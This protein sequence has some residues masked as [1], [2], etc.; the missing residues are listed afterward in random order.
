VCL[1]LVVAPCFAIVVGAQA[2]GSISGTVKDSTGGV[3]PGVAVTAT[4]VA[5]GTQTTVTTDTQGLYSF[6]RLPVGRYDL[7]IQLEGFKPQK[8]TGL[9]V[10]ADSALQENAT[11][12]V[13]GQTETVTVT[14]TEV[15]VETQST[16]LGEVVSAQQMTTLSLN[17]RSYTDLLAIQ[18]GVIPVTTIQANSVIMAGVTGT[19]APS[20]ELNAGNVSVSG[21]RESANGFLVNGGDVQEHMNGGTSIVPNLDSIE[22]FRLLTNNFDPQYGNYNGGIVNVIT[23][24]GSD[25]FHGS[26]FELFRNTALDGR[27]YFSPDRASFNQN[28]PG[29]TIGGPIKKGKVFFFSDYQAT[30]TTQGVETGLIQVPS[31]QQRLGNF[32]DAASSLSGTVNGQYWA[33]LLAQH[34]GYRVFP[35]EAYYTPGCTS[36]SQCVF[37]NAIIP[38]SAW[39][40]PAQQLLQYIPSQNSGEGL[41][42]TGAYPRTVRDDKFSTRIDGNTR[43]GLVSGY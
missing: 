27:N 43:F 6:P 22:E 17:G 26:G 20:G 4:N 11:L 37:P 42:S 23:K 10:S 31:D 1:S 36:S 8:R 9:A 2:G 5:L 32:S 28:Q 12:E 35:G 15:R 7:T 13:G 25:A 41:F 24:S 34:L 16:Q 18:P 14:S 3:V 21:Q 38:S 33:D 29:G 39:S 40:A 30:R 19:V